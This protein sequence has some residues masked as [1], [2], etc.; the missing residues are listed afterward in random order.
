[1]KQGTHPNSLKNLKP[2]WTTETA[3]IAQ[4]NSV[5]ARKANAEAR[6]NL[7]MTM[8]EWEKYKTEVLANSNVS[9][10]DILKILMMKAL[11]NDEFEQAAD[12]AK[13]LAEFE[14]PKL[15]RIDQTNVDISAEDMTDE[16]LEAKLKELNVSKDDE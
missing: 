15:A 12:L 14:A 5:I 10:I 13:T 16:E 1:M 2:A 6:A 3:R 9:S 8:K 4:K 7:N 11:E